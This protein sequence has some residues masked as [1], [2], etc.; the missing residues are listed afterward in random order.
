M[1]MDL[2][3]RWVHVLSASILVGGAFFLRFSMAPLWASQT[4]EAR[5]AALAVWRPGWSRL[6]MMASGLLLVSGLVNAVL[7]IKRHDFGDAP[8]H[9]FVAGKLVLAMI[10]FW[11]NAVLAGRSET[12]E[13]FRK[14]L[15][16]WLN[17]NLILVIVTVAVGGY[18]K[19]MPR[20]LKSAATS[21]A[22]EAQT[23]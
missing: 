5:R 15:V 12:A 16:K 7:M 2:L 9:A 11:L 20:E 14:D 13:R 19:L 18:M 1:L 4:E 3:L 17:V 10:L 21:T 23:P 8:Y 22:V 6:V